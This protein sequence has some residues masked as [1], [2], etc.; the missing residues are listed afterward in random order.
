MA[1]RIVYIAHQL[2]APTRALIEANRRNAANWV[3]WLA[4]EFDIAP[5]ADWIVL[6]GGWDETPENRERGLQIDCTLVAICDEMWMVG[7]RASEGMLRE[8]AHAKKVRDLT[9]FGKSPYPA[10]RAELAAEVD[11]P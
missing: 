5:V 11:L 4:Q 7:G 6:T 9:R 3:C 1:K 10:L 8:A 2:N